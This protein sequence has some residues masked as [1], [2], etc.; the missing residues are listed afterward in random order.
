MAQ[1]FDCKAAVGPLRRG[2]AMHPAGQPGLEKPRLPNCDAG[3]ETGALL[4]RRK[5]AR[6]RENRIGGGDPIQSDFSP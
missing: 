2:R 6:A 5:K 1:N 4:E 3:W